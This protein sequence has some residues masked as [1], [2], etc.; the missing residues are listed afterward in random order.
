MKPDDLQ[1]QIEFRE[2]K[3]ADLR[4]QL[5]VL[6]GEVRG[7]RLAMKYMHNPSLISATAIPAIE[8]PSFSAPTREVEANSNQERR[9]GRQHGSISMPWRRILAHL[10]Q[11]HP[12]GFGDEDVIAAAR[13]EN[14]RLRP[15]D[16]RDRMHHY[17]KTKLIDIASDGR[18]SV[19]SAANER[20]KLSI[21]S[22]L[23]K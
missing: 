4:R 23:F 7:M 13:L 15:K 18:Y 3:I 17:Q 1:T 11:E 20:F 21:M 9:G 14:I 10:L 5:D 16:A 2:R 12:L 6:E 8:S 19:S 22:E